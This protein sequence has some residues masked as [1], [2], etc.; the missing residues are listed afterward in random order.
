MS[1]RSGSRPL[2][3]L[4]CH[5]LEWGFHRR[6]L[7][8]AVLSFIPCGCLGCPVS[9]TLHFLV[10]RW[11]CSRAWI[12]PSP[13]H[14]SDCLPRWIVRICLCSPPCCCYWGESEDLL[15]LFGVSNK[16]DLVTSGR[17]SLKPTTA[18][19]DLWQWVLDSVAR[20]GKE[21]VK[22]YKTAAH[23]KLQQA[24]CRHGAWLIWHN[25]QVDLTCTEVAVFGQSGRTM[26]KQFKQR[27]CCINRC[28]ISTWLLPSGVPRRKKTELWMKF[29]LL[30]RDQ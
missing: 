21:N 9:Q 12:W 22:V 2:W 24:R 7:S 14:V 29:L 10:A 28:V 4:L 18:S 3:L 17:A 19:T 6:F 1:A 26:W 13:G 25:H 11:W 16:Y 8:V 27:Q 23:R 30:L 5:C 15:W 20:F